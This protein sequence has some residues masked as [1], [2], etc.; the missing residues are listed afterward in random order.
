M[1]GGGGGKGGWRGVGEGLGSDW[2]RVGGRG[3]RGLGKVWG[4]VGEDLLLAWLSI[5]Q[6]P[7]LKNPLTFPLLSYDFL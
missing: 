2:G 5:F 4:R 3:G 1:G 6:K 7:R